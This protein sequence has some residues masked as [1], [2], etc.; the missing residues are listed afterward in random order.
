VTNYS[1]HIGN[2]FGPNGFSISSTRP[3]SSSK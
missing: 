2:S 1:D 3:A